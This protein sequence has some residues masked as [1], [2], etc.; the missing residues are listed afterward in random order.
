MASRGMA[1]IIMASLLVVM[2]LA[3]C[4]SKA[5]PTNAT[6]PAKPPTPR[7]AATS[8]KLAKGLRLTITPTALSGDSY[9]V[10]TVEVTEVSRDGFM[11]SWNQTDRAETDA[12]IKRREAFEKGRP[13]VGVGEKEPEPPQ[14]EHEDILSKGKM[15]VVGLDESREMLLPALWQQ[16]TST[17]GENS[18][19]WMSRKAFLELRSTRK[20]SWDAGLMANPPGSLMK[21]S[22]AIKDGLVALR[23]TAE[24]EAKRSAMSTIEA[25]PDFGTFTLLLDGQE[26]AVETV[27]AGNWLARYAILNNA[28]NPLILKATINPI[29]AGAIDILSPFGALTSTL[30]YEVTA[31]RTR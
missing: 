22:D 29:S 6:E 8:I 26:T 3:S 10:K 18:L 9:G 5:S 28:E 16:G 15:T 21:L 2:L 11:I 31:V 1:S 7:E 17:I 27:E 30:G 12:S 19:I 23:K 20:A 14:P 25:E 4:A 13:P 24:D